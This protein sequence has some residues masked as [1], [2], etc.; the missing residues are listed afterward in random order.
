MDSRRWPGGPALRAALV[1]AAALCGMATAPAAANGWRAFALLR[2][3]SDVIGHDVT[4]RP[5][6]SVLVGGFRDGQQ[7]VIRIAPNG[8]RS[9]FA[10][11]GTPVYPQRL[12]EGGPAAKAELGEVVGLAAAPDGA[13]LIVDRVNHLVRRVGRDGTITTVAGMFVRDQFDS[14]YGV[15]G[16]AGDGG[17]ATSALLC[18]PGGVAALPEGGFLIADAGNQVVRKVA[19]DGTISTVAGVSSQCASDPSG[20]GRPP[21]PNGGPAISTRLAG[22][23][24]VAP[25]ADGGFLIA[26]G[27]AG[28]RRV[29]PDGTIALAAP[30]NVLSV[31]AMQDGR[32]AYLGPGR[33]VVRVATLGGGVTTIAG[34]RSRA[35]RPPRPIEAFLGSDGLD[36]GRLG[37]DGLGGLARDPLGGLLVAD[38]PR[39]VQL[40]E[41]PSRRMALAIRGARAGRR[42]ATLTYFATAAGAVEVEARDLFAIRGKPRK[43]RGRARAGLNTVRLPRTRPGAYTVTVRATARNGTRDGDQVGIVLG[44]RLPISAASTLVGEHECDG[45][46]EV[47]APD[48]TEVVGRCRRFARTRVDCRIDAREIGSCEWVGSA[49]LRPSG[50]VWT[51]RY[52][53][54]VRRVL[55]RPRPLAPAPLP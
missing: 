46:C 17:P 53:C 1:A 40:V 13:V 11:T 44:A 25:L 9:L 36:A 28:V 15:S 10:G 8:R 41:P 12:G 54:P 29:L 20:R 5:D 43:R 42:G 22:P 32:F 14:E 51:R 30:G 35:G 6:G 34:R 19:A 4:V 45:G 50:F 18:S 16:F 52:P 7:Q 26:D 27:D 49:V 37:L 48:T 55:R 47:D 33:D 39:L 3:E 24:D 31:D 2:F 21:G 38:G 23:T